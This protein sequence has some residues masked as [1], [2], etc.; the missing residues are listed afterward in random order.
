MVVASTHLAR[1]AYR[2]VTRRGPRG[3]LGK[4]VRI[5]GQR[6]GI[7]FRRADAGSGAPA[8]VRGRRAAVAGRVSTGDLPTGGGCKGAAAGLTL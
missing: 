3:S 6:P 7:A 8:D 5:A 4:A 2:R 1:E